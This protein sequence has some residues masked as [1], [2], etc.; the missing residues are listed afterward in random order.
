MKNFKFLFL[1]LMIFVLAFLSGCAA[2]GKFAGGFLTATTADLSVCAVQGMY[3][4]N[5]YPQ[6][7]KTVEM[8]YVGDQWKEGRA[9]VAVSFYK[10][11]GIGFYKVDG[12]IR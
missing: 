7:T 2:I 5:L 4:S 8:D 10:R 6:D 11:D 9:G 1:I 3:M 12:T